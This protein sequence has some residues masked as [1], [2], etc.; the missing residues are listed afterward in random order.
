MEGLEDKLGSILSNPQLMGQIMDMARSLGGE[1]APA[2][3][4]QP[5]REP[6]GEEPMASMPPMDLGM[7]RKIAG[8]AGQTGIDPNQR[9]LLKALGPYL[10][11][12]RILRLEKAMRA[13]K[14]AGAASAFLAGNSSDR[15]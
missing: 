4:P 11:R 8:I 14:L 1:D 5:S 6:P 10:S 12:D 13:A 7:I 15:G 9:E 2:D 3:P